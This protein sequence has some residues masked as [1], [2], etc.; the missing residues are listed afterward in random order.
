MFNSLLHTIGS[1]MKGKRRSLIG[2]GLLAIGLV[3]FM[4]LGPSPARS[5]GNYLAKLRIND[6]PSAALLSDNSPYGALYIDHRLLDGDFCVTALAQGGWVFIYLDYNPEVGFGCSKNREITPR[7]YTLVLPEGCG[8]TDR[9]SFR[10]RSENLFGKKRTTT[11]AFMFFDGV[12][13]YEVMPDVE[14]AITGGGNTRTLTY[15]GTATLWRFTKI[16]KGER[17]PVRI[18]SSFSFPFEIT[19]ERV[20]Q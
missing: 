15:S 1:W 14:V 3:A 18:C 12:I 10:I 19:V 6:F 8:P 5:G 4:A 11:V 7:T 13:G 9:E 2:L 16:S 17:V 20:A